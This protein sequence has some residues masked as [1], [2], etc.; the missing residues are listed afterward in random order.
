[1][2]VHLLHVLTSGLQI[3]TRIEVVRM[4]SEI[5]TDGSGHGKTR[6][7][8]DVDLAD[9]T[10]RCLAELLLRNTYSVG[11]VTTVLVDR[12]NLVLWNGRRAVEHD[13]ESR[14]LL[15]DL[16]QHVESEWRRNELTGLR[17]TCALLGLE[18]ISTMRSTDGDSKRV[19]AC[20]GSEVNH[21]LG[22]GVVAY[23]RG[24]L[25]LNTSEDTELTLY[26]NIILVCIL[27]NL[28]GD[29]D[30]LLVRQ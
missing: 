29:L 2:D 10:L 21:L 30:V 13:G 16:S 26:G 27:Y 23:L 28:T 18:L 9:S 24:N 20:A 4:L 11:Q 1:M 6:V 12:V 7:R 25:I 22:L 3:L 15:L 8:V 14:K 5:L 17:V 19:A